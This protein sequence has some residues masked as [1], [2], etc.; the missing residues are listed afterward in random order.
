M[1]TVLLITALGGA[2]VAALGVLAAIAPA[3]DDGL[4]ADPYLD[5]EA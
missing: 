5:M 2:A 3:D 1:A 4:E